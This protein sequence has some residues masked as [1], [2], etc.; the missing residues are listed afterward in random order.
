MGVSRVLALSAAVFLAVT[1][2]AHGQAISTSQVQGVVHDATGSVLPGVTVTMTNVGTGLSRSAVSD[3]DGGYVLQALPPG[4]YR[5]DAMLQGFKSYSQSGIVL[6][7]GVNP[8]IAI[9]LDVDDI[10]AVR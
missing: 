1:V 6:E 9:A 5:L 7:V 3:S 8:R 2:A 10:V 4:A